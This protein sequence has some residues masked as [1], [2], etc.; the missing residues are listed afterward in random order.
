[1]ANFKSMDDSLASTLPPTSNGDLFLRY[2]TNQEMYLYLFI[3]T[4]IFILGRESSRLKC[5]SMLSPIFVSHKISLLAND[6]LLIFVPSDLKYL[7]K[8]I[9]KFNLDGWLAS[10]ICPTSNGDLFLRYFTTQEMSLYIFII[11]RF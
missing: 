7:E 11:L 3:F 1:M 8:P 6:H 2:F 9:A 10:D 5:N 4:F